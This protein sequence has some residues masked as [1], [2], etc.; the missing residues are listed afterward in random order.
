MGPG[1]SSLRPHRPDARAF[2]V[3]ANS[4][5]NAFGSGVIT[6]GRC[7]GQE[8]DADASVGAGHARRARLSVAR[9]RVWTT[10]TRLA[11]TLDGIHRMSVMVR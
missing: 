5:A 8:L 7:G 1:C 10:S 11:A 4:L 2:G 9:E 6:Q 3:S